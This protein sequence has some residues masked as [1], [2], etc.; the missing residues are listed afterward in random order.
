[1]C[2]ERD[3]AVLIPGELKRPIGKRGSRRS[4][5]TRTLSCFHAWSLSANPNSYKPSGSAPASLLPRAESCLRRVGDPRGGDGGGDGASRQTPDLQTPSKAG[6]QGETSSW[7]ECSTN[8]LAM[9]SGSKRPHQERKR[10]PAS[11]ACPQGP[12]TQQPSPVRA[13]RERLPHRRWRRLDI[14]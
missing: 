1:M 13:S 4:V 10:P 9:G 2:A 8:P 11:A 12:G 3:S 14:R 7:P 6:Q 5:I